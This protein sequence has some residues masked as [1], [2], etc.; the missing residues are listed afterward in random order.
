MIY[1]RDVFAGVRV[2]PCRPHSVCGNSHYDSRPVLRYC[3]KSYHYIKMERYGF[4]SI[5][6]R[7]I[8]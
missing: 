7:R 5:L 1:L 3:K 4:R 6:T 2:S 8:R